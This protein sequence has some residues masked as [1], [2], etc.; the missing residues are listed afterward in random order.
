MKRELCIYQQEHIKI[1]EGIVDQLHESYLRVINLTEQTDFKSINI[2]HKPKILPLRSIT[3]KQAFT[4]RG[5]T[6]QIDDTANKLYLQLDEN[7]IMVKINQLESNLNLQKLFNTQLKRNND[8]YKNQ[9]QKYSEM[10][11]EIEKSSY[12]AEKTERERW[13]KIFTE[14]RENSERE[15]AR[16]QEEI[17]QLNEI[18]GSWINSF[19]IVQESAGFNIMVQEQYQNIQT[20]IIRTVES[21]E[22]ININPLKFSF[23]SPIIPSKSSSP[24]FKSFK[25]DVPVE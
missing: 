15:L 11:N 18:L 3:H 25:G 10:L 9:A 14:I 5:F 1:I 23:S 4:S 16:K 21:L 6:K 13:K 24:F 17:I 2:Q 12:L 7:S 20:L 8:I 19:M 22:Q